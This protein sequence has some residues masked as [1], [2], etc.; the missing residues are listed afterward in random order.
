MPEPI[1][2]AIAAFGAIKTAVGAGKSIAELGKDI[3]TLFDA[4]DDCRYAHTRKKDSVFT[5]SAN[6]QALDTFVKL[7]EAKDLENNL[8]EIIIATRGF[9]AWQELIALRSQIRRERKEQQEALERQ[10]EER[11]DAIVMYG[12]VGVIVLVL[13]GLAILILLGMTGRI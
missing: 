7:Q 4:I 1:T 13:S 9:N 2:M 10:R 8:R 6:E 5:G 12:I 11:F 3:G